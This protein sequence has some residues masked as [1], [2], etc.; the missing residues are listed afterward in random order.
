MH[1]KELLS[2]NESI[3]RGA[4]EAGVKVATGYPGTPSTEILENIVQYKKDL[5][6]EWSPNEK[7]AF[8]V[9]VGASLTGARCITTMKHVG[10][11]VAADPLMTFAYV[12]AVGGFVA[13]VAD[14]P[15]MHS[16]QNEQDT[17]QYAKFAKIPVFEPAD[18]QECV[19]F[20]RMAMDISEK[21]TTPVILRTTTRVSHSRSMV[22]MKDRTPGEHKIGFEK[23]P[24]RFVP[25]PAWARQ[26]RVR[27][28]DRLEKLK[29]ASETSPANRL[30]WRDKEL[31][32]ITHS[33]TYQ[34][35][36]DTF[37]EASVL[38]LGMSFPFP[39]KLIREFAGGVKRLLV[40]E[41][42]D[43][44]IEEHVKAMGITCEG[45]NLVPRIG[46][47]SPNAMEVIK[48]K[49]EG[50]ELPEV[51]PVAEA[52][53]LPARPPVLCAG[54]PHR[55]MF[56]ALAQEDV[57]VTGDI[58]CYSLG[59]MPPLGRMDTILCMGGGI[60]LAHGMDKAG[61]P[62][63]VVGIVGDSTF[64]HSGIT[65]L[66]NIA[67]NKGAS[68]I[69]V[70]DNRITAMTGHQ[71]NPGSGLTLM[72]DTTVEASIEE[73]GKAC[74]IKKIYTINP[75]DQEKTSQVLKDCLASDE[76]TLIV[77]RAP[78][79]LYEKKPV[80]PPLVID[81]DICVECGQC[82]ELGCPALEAAEGSPSIN[83]FLCGGCNLCLQ[84]C[85]VEAIHV[86]E[87]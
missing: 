56:Y 18:S 11:N 15:G 49:M 69:I 62:K 40:V 55:G 41:E 31:G 73:I 33:I 8:E 60:T 3:A 83:E 64:F 51:K 81:K 54:C 48:A 22:E 4:W 80:G 65:G 23:N 27:L 43:E 68:T 37:P 35:V 52:S 76:P 1:L 36:R 57:I 72:G 42:L 46:E 21:Y 71:E 39:D 30:E 66:L 87:D 63:K 24:P 26:M 50:R 47:L 19:D 7:V 14:D 67:Y 5:Y 61:E 20:M 2:G 74:G 84:V 53:D 59:V 70:V 58:G 25:I 13:C 44:F 79:L 12:G 78:C 77:S 45:K 34:Y 16:S 86:K 28:E 82:L 38:K 85:Q 6:C 10:L 75:Y 29:E 32:I 17:R 9:A